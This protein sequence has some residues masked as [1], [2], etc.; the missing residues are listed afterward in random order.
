MMKALVLFWLFLINYAQCDVTR[1]AVEDTDGT[2]RD[3]VT[4]TDEVENRTISLKYKFAMQVKNILM[5]EGIN[6][7]NE[8]SIAERGDTLKDIYNDID[9]LL[10][11]GRMQQMYVCIR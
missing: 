1:R 9:S 3:V 8:N 4:T 5:N 2:V 7:E 10:E 11:L 6:S